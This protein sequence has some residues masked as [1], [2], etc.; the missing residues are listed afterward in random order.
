MWAHLF[1]DEIE[2]GLGLGSTRGE[3]RQR[4]AWDGNTRGV[5]RGCTGVGTGVDRGAVL[6]IEYVGTLVRALALSHLCG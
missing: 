2:L 3:E 4:E 6:V 1:Y 5:E